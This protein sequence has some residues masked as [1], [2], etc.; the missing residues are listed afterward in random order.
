[1]QNN[2]VRKA[3]QDAGVA[4]IVRAAMERWPED[5]G[6]SEAGPKLV[7]KLDKVNKGKE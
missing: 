7:K 3:V 5:E 1:M 4:D 6:L 2:D